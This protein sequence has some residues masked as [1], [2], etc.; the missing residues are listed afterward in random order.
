[1]P[2]PGKP[3]SFCRA[4][5]A[6]V[7][8]AG[9]AAHIDTGFAGSSAVLVAQVH[10]FWSPEIPPKKPVSSPNSPASVWYP[11][12]QFCRS[13]LKQKGGLFWILCARVC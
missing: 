3:E 2:M 12:V 1:M 8:T 13:T 11:G 7:E 4:S 10:S 5:T 6:V 9:A